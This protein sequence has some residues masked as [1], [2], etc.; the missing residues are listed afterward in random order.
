MPALFDDTVL[1]ASLNAIAAATTLHICSGTPTDFASVG[2]NSLASVALTS[3]DFAQAN[4]PTSGRQVTVAAQSDVEVTASGAPAYYCLVDTD[5]LLAMTEVDSA[6]P[7]LTDGS[8]TD[9]PAVTFS[10]A[11]PTVV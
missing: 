4:H 8:S 2:S 9:I 1:N 5:T 3:G 7:D 11:D 10:V 6:S